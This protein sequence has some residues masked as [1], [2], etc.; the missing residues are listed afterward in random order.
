MGEQSWKPLYFYKNISARQFS[1][2]LV[3]TS[4]SE[5]AR[6]WALKIQAKEEKFK[7]YMINKK[8]FGCRETFQ[9]KNVTQ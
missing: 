5:A 6:G 3:N 1:K 8:S 2:N 9:D 7:K 4:N